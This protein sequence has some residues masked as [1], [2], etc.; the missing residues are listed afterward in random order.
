[1]NDKFDKLQKDT[2]A[3]FLSTH[4][5]INLTQT[6]KKLH[7][8]FSPRVNEKKLLHQLLIHVV[9]A[10]YSAV[11]ALLQTHIH[12]LLQQGSV[13]DCSGRKFNAISPFAY[14]LW[15]LDKPM[16][17]IM[18]QGLSKEQNNALLIEQLL[19]ILET[20]NTEGITYTYCGKQITE[21]HFNFAETL[22]KE[23]QKQVN[24]ANAPAPRWHFIDKQ[25]IKGVGGAQ[26]LL[27]MHVVYEYCA[28][29][30]FDPLPD[31]KAPVLPIRKFYNWYSKKEE[32][33]FNKDTK[34]GLEFALYKGNS[35]NKVNVGFGACTLHV[36]ID[37]VA[38][39]ELVRVRLHDYSLLKTQLENQLSIDTQ[40]L[41]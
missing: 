21:A 34:L 1:M 38:M 24:A 36:D 39:K 5:L 30:R 27:P 41:A 12:L 29:D 7:S 9:R 20:L 10:E 14:S 22:I 26:K 4:E 11:A 19:S 23:L 33:W 31:F 6:S 37:L 16:W 13:T 17:T 28:R 15:A 35:V 2:T 40:Y 18:L 25:W 32:D 8:L 3:Q